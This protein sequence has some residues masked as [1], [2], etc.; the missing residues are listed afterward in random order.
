MTVCAVCHSSN[1][2]KNESGQWVATGDPTELAL[3]IFALRFNK[4]KQ[5]L[6][7]DYSFVAE[8]PFDSAIKRMTV[9]RKTKEGDFV[10]FAKGA[11]EGILS[12]AIG[13]YDENGNVV[14]GIT[15]EYRAHVN[16]SMEKM[17]KKGLRVLATGIRYT[18][19]EDLS[20][21]ELA[22]LEA[23]EDRDAIEKN[24]VFIG[25]I[26]MH[27]PPRPETAGA[28]R[29]AQ[30]AGIVVHMATGDH[31]LT[32][33]TIAK[34]VG[35]LRRPIRDEHV[36][37]AAN[38]D[39]MTDEEVDRM[40]DLPLVLARCS[41]QSKV[42]L[43]RALHRRGKRVAM[44]GDGVND[45]PA[46]KNADVGVSMGQGG[47]DVT[48][49]A[50]DITLTDDNFAT[51][52]GAVAEGRR[53]FA[54]I[55]KF[56]LHLLSGNVSEVISLVL[57]LAV[58][59]ANNK[60][61]FPMSAVQILYLNLLTSSPVALALG[62]EVGSKDIMRQAPRKYGVFHFELIMDTAVYG[63]IL[64]TLSLV[65]YILN[66]IWIRG[67]PFESFEEC[68]EKYREEC[69]P[70]FDAR[71]VGFYALSLG[72]L[73]HGFVCR[74]TRRSTFRQKLKGSMALIGSIVFG[75]V[76]IVPTAYIPVINTEVFKQGI[77]DGIGWAF[78]FVCLVI[79][80]IL[81]EIYKFLKR[82]FMADLHAVPIVDQDNAGTSDE[83]SE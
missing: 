41:P 77:V 8:A 34:E 50:S 1:L 36:M 80:M 53:I 63:A 4:T 78:I 33:R 75:V 18:K 51:I 47:S 52:T 57:G 35:I 58:R 14:E 21:D 44:T 25:L 82:T 16:K 59:D 29:E 11:I 5:S 74:H 55:C 70:I 43:V 24:F 10:C 68:N 45:A 72:I 37:I 39:N 69:D 67:T 31:P 40:Q 27:D 26:A 60:F 64:G 71:A 19:N 22:V 2:T 30:G 62:V 79:H 54:N 42:K 13:Y 28:V 66:V 20:K 65:S 49:Q 12:R 73:E 9:V 56:A 7:D 6:E 38:F 61:I 23:G 81:S 17:A 76:L 3:V 15:A 48:R 83:D 46:V 32:A